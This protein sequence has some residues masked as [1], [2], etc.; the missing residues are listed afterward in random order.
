M[1]VEP[2]DET[3]VFAPC[4][5]IR[6]M[7]YPEIFPETAMAASKA[8]RKAL[9]RYRE[10][11]VA[12]GRVRVEFS[13]LPEDREL[14]RALVARL[15]GPVG[16]LTRQKLLAIAGATSPEAR[17]G[18]IVAALL[19]SPLHGSG[20]DLSRTRDLELDRGFEF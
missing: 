11:L 20:L 7:M 10:R 13:V 2:K 19:A 17:A 1:K 4:T 18:G 8:Q 12:S 16:D 15:D 3:E 14:L 6:T 9:E 5:Q